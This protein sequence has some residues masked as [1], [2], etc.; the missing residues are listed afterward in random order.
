MRALVISGGG[1]KGAF[2]GG[3]A[4]FLIEGAQHKYD[5]FVGTSTGSLL[6]SHLALNK[7]DKIKEIYSSV[8]QESIF[9]NCPFIIK[10]KHGVEI[11]AINQ[12]RYH[13]WS[14]LMMHLY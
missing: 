10:K 6:I 13:P 8:N 4:Q 3:V 14:P 5:L 1:S 2:A 11:I 7:L 9:N 12:G